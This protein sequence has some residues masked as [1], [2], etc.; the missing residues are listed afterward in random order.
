MVAPLAITVDWPAGVGPQDGGE[1]HFDGHDALPGRRPPRPEGRR[2]GPTNVDDF[3]QHSTGPVSPGLDH[4][5]LL[6]DHLPV[7]PVRPDMGWVS[8]SDTST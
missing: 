6:V 5:R 7:D 8:R 1:P 3:G 4:D 2:T